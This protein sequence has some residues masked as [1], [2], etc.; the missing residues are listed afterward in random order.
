MIRQ[1]GLGGTIVA[2]LLAASVSAG[3][4]GQQS[5]LSIGAGA[6]GIAMGGGVTAL[7]SNSSAMYYNPAGLSWLEYQEFA[8]Q[9]THLALGT[10]YDYGAWVYP[11]SEDHGIGIGYMRIGTGDIIRRTEFQDI[12]KFSFAESQLMISYGQR[13]GW[14]STGV[15][16]KI[17]N[18]SVDQYSDYGVGLG[19]GVVANL[20][21][22]WRLGGIVRD[23][24]PARIRLRDISQKVP[25]TFAAGLAVDRWK[26]SPQTALTMACDVE[27]SDRRTAKMHAGMEAMFFGLYAVRAGYDRN[28][29]TV[30]AGVRAGRIVADY[31]LKFQ[32]DLADQHSFSLSFLIGPSVGDQI[33]RREALRRAAFEIDPRVVLINALKDTA[34]SYMHQFRLDSSL[35]YFQKLY[36]LEPTNQEYIGTIA[37]IENAQ[38][39]QQEQ[40]ARLR[41]ARAE[42]EQFLRSYYDQ[43][44][45]FFDKKYYSAAND[46]LKLVLDIQPNNADALALRDRIN[47]AVAADI[48]GYLESA[49][50]AEAQ[51]SRFELIES[52]DRVLALDSTNTWAKEARIRALAGL[53]IGKHLNIGIDLFNKGQTAEAARRFRSVLEARPN[54]VV[55][56]EYLAKIDSGVARVATLEDI[57]KDRVIWQIYIDGLK[58]MRDQQFQKAIDVW[59]KVLET[60][61][62]QPNTLN[63]IEQARL[64]LK[65]ENSG[66]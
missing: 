53:D 54:D 59:Q 3:D 19:V 56:R 18:Q 61:P 65:A 55:A 62:N 31:A 63:N 66:Q 11:M 38:R 20:G 64:R 33:K 4:A 52:C 17:V 10:T 23:L 32:S 34:N 13:F 21:G 25:Q 60:Y 14:L 24:M 1:I 26:I 50:Q 28:N 40:E 46:L 30:G 43:A 45:S 44:Q 7:A 8:I 15:T 42:Q 48:A 47:Q 36:E 12:G 9:Y 16:L 51:A 29:V 49:R 35:A 39:V 22:P 41:A 57:Q 2:F 5:P 37:A 58:H 6:R 27:G